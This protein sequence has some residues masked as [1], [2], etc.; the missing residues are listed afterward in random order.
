MIVLDTNIISELAK[1][2]TDKKVLD[3]FFTLDSQPVAT[4]TISLAELYYGIYV[5]PEGKRKVELEKAVTL[6]IE[7]VLGD[8]LLAFDFRAGYIY[9]ALVVRLRQEGL[10]IS[11]SDAMIAAITKVHDGILITRNVKDFRHCGIEI[12]NPFD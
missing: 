11:Q 6:V 9:A 2:D 1:Q 5:L 8:S 7:D 4:T 10:S 12:L 3:W